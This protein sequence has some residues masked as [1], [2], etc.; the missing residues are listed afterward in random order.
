MHK[1]RRAICQLHP[2]CSALQTGLCVGSACGLTGAWCRVQ[3]WRAEHGLCNAIRLALE[4]IAWR[5]DPK[6][7]L[8]K[9]VSLTTRAAAAAGALP[10]EQR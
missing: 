8:A 9:L 7:G 3:L 6:L 2:G 4:Q 1:R 10:L 5:A